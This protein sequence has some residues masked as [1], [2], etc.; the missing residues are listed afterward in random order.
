[1]G[2][3]E[4]EVLRRLEDSAPTIGAEVMIHTSSIPIP[5]LVQAAS[6][7]SAMGRVKETENCGFCG[8]KHRFTHETKQ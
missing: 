6:T 3:H 2:T 1:M 4:A 8:A 7:G 5:I